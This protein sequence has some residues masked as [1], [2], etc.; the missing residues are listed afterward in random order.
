VISSRIPA[1]EPVA[2]SVST[3]FDWG[4]AGIG[5]GA[6]LGAVLLAATGAGFVRHNR[7]RLSSV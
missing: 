3:S 1:T 5:A 6:A 4:D 7:R 2:T